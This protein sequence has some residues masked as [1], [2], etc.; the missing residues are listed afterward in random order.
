MLQQ[1]LQNFRDSKSKIKNPP[2]AST[3]VRSGKLQ[4][5]AA[6]QWLQTA[7]TF[8]QSTIKQ[9]TALNGDDSGRQS[10]T[11]NND[12]QSLTNVYG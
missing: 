7:S 11:R 1:N 2:K 6:R 8:L 10:P 12:A 3:L 5:K 4:T 9:L